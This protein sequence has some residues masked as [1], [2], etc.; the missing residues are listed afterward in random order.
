MAITVSGRN[1]GL[2]RKLRLTFPLGVPFVS[3]L[4]QPIKWA[5]SLLACFP[6]YETDSFVL[7]ANGLLSPIGLF[8]RNSHA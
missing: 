5:I 7:S 1:H 8:G 2:A 3:W 6:K 4:K